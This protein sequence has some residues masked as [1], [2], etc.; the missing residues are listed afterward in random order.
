MLKE[1]SHGKRPK[2]GYEVKVSMKVTE[3]DTIVD[4]ETDSST[5]SAAIHWIL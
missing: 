4:V 1:D 2:A 3:E 5:Q